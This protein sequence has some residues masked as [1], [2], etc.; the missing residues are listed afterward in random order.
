METLARE[1]EIEPFFNEPDED[2]LIRTQV[3]K[4]SQTL[5]TISLLKN[6]VETVAVSK[7]GKYIQI[8]VF[9]CFCVGE[10]L[11]SIW[12]TV[13][14]PISGQWAII[15]DSRGFKHLTGCT[16]SKDEN[17]TNSEVFYES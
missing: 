2:I 11:L 1:N 13:T 8:E 17:C 6:L 16:V 5:V 4:L 7:T 15:M 3:W 14:R 9:N 12:C 10:H